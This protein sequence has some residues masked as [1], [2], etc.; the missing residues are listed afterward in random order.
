MDAEFAKDQAEE[1]TGRLAIEEESLRIL[2][3]AA[4]AQLNVQQAEIQRLQEIVAFQRARFDALTVRSPLAGVVQEIPSETGQWIN[5]GQTLVKLHATDKLKATLRVPAIDAKDVT[6][7]Q[8]V[9]VD[10]RNGVVPGRVTRVNPAVQGGVVL[11]DVALGELPQGARP[12]LSVDGVI[13]VARQPNTLHVARMAVPESDRTTFI[14]KIS[15]DGKEGTR[16]AVQIGQVS[17]TMVEIRA[18][19]TRGDVV[20]TSAMPIPDQPERIRLRH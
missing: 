3:G 1:L 12:D 13:E 18:G 5:P 8:P 2:T 16:T 6:V 10:T 4:A 15:K 7:G 11:V 9:A 14:Y 19:L 17:P 20:I